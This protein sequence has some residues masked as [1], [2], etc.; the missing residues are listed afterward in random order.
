MG[1][2]ADGKREPR[3]RRKTRRVKGGDVAKG[4]K[5]SL[6][7]RAAALLFAL[8]LVALAAKLWLSP[9]PDAPVAEAGEE[10]VEEEESA[11]VVATGPPP[12]AYE[13]I[14]AEDRAALRELLRDS[15]GAPE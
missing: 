4:A 1:M 9:E 12:P 13:E 15:E 3:A 5:T 14:P 11:D 7:V 8:A 10:V 2:T 6:A